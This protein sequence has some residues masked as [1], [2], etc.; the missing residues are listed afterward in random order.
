MSLFLPVLLLC[1][2]PA[3]DDPVVLPLD[4]AKVQSSTSVVVDPESFKFGSTPAASATVWERRPFG[5]ENVCY[6][7][8]SYIFERRD[9]LAPELVGM[10]TCL[11]AKAM[12]QKRVRGGTRLVPAR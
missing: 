1:F 3:S 5:G 11:P 4:Q 7:M 12:A 6:T 9:N 2:A 8:R 10:T